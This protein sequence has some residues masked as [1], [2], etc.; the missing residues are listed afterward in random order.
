MIEL[1]KIPISGGSGAVRRRKQEIDDQ[2]D[3]IC[4]SIGAVKMRLKNKRF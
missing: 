3:E 1:Q 2:L 4:Q